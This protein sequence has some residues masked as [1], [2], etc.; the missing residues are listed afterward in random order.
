MERQKRHSIHRKFN[1]EVDQFSNIKVNVYDIDKF[2]SD[3]TNGEY[4]AFE[5]RHGAAIL[6][7]KDGTGCIVDY[8]AVGESFDSINDE[9]TI[10]VNKIDKNSNNKKPV[11]IVPSHN[12][13]A[14]VSEI[15]D[16]APVK[17]MTV[18][19]FFTKRNYNS[20]CY[21]NFSDIKEYLT[22]NRK[23]FKK[24]RVSEDIFDRSNGVPEVSY[25]VA[26]D[27]LNQI[28]GQNFISYD[29]YQDL[30]DKAFT[31]YLG[32]DY[33]QD[34]RYDDDFDADVR[35][36]L[37]Y[38][39]WDTDF[40]TGDLYDINHTVESVNLPVPR[41]R[42]TESKKRAP[43]VRSYKR[44]KESLRKSRK[45]EGKHTIKLFNDRKYKKHIKESTVLSL[46]S[47]YDMYDLDDALWSGGRDR[48]TEYSDDQK[49][50]LMDYFEESTYGSD[51]IPSLTSFN[52]FIWFD[53]DDI[54]VE[55]GYGYEP[56]DADIQKLADVV[57]DH[58]ETELTL[59]DSSYDD[60][61]T[62]LYLSFSYID[63]DGEEDTVDVQFRISDEMG[64][65]Y[66]YVNEDTFADKV[67]PYVISE[68]EYEDIK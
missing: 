56:D 15:L 2:V 32:K 8:E 30:Y 57:N 24:K 29:E 20:R 53:A 23:S 36:I 25:L 21:S 19:E 40:S 68:L 33:Y 11:F 62:E 26:E 59:Y 50:F 22:E 63:E 45:L 14:T 3:E 18:D 55:N 52:D 5:Y 13:K 37:G 60:S 9:V 66:L 61:D 48:W 65:D 34:S 4:I 49:E 47:D 28:D 41:N 6:F 31:K 10:G 27:I 54:L 39:G 1:E 12:I 16:S 58:F 38:S 46:T 51:E 35:G 64:T 44:V 67:A 17:S 43:R 42:R 7:K